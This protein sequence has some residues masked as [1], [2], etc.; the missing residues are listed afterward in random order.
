MKYAALILALAACGGDPAEL[1]LDLIEP[2]ATVELLPG[3]AV[4][5]TWTITGGDAEMVVTLT[6]ITTDDTIIIYDEPAAEGAGGFTW[7]GED[8]TGALVLPDVYDLEATLFVDGDPGDSKVRN[9]SVH[10]VYVTTPV[11]GDELTIAGSA[12]PVD[13]H[14]VTVSQRVIHLRT[15]LVPAVGAEILIDDRTIPGE[16]VPFERD[17][18]V[19]GL[20]TAGVAIPEGDYTVVVDVTDDDDPDLAYRSTGGV[21]HWRPNA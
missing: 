1:E 10:G 2:S 21:V 15:R 8:V 3:G 17:V 16:F 11:P 9:L 14:Y 5:V 12:V 7:D 18:H 19:T 4:D 6:P 13:V 20:D